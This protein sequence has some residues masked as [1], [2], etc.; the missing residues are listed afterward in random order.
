MI[1]IYKDQLYNELEVEYDRL[2]NRMKFLLNLLRFTRPFVEPGALVVLA[3]IDDA[4]GSPTMDG[5]PK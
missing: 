3:A 1:E 5:T 4:I 2:Q